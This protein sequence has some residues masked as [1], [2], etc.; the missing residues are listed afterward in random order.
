MLAIGQ[1]LKDRR[2]LALR[3]HA[4]AVGDHEAR[5]CTMSSTIMP[6]CLPRARSR[7]PTAVAP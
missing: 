3:A 2:E 7:N 4:A 6:E 1:V 5:V